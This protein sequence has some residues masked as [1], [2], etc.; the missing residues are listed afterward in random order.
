LA[1]GLVTVEDDEHDQNLL[2]DCMCLTLVKCILDVLR[3]LM[4][5]GC[6]VQFLEST[7]SGEI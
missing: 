5:L 1:R 6:V 7:E 3:F 2:S 4:G